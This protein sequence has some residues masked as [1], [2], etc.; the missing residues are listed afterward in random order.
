VESTWEED[1]DDGEEE[2]K[3]EDKSDEDYEEEEEQ[4]QPFNPLTD[5]A[6]NSGATATKQAKWTHAGRSFVKT[7]HIIASKEEEQ[8]QDAQDLFEQLKA[9]EPIFKVVRLCW[10]HVINIESQF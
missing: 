1:D 3:D 5:D 8:N 10:R 4:T 9:L 6:A 2:D 7:E